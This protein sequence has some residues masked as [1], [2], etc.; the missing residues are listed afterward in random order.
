MS[1]DVFRR[2][3]RTLALVAGMW[4]AVPSLTSA[5][6]IT[7][8]TAT[9]FQ[10]IE[11]FG[12]CLPWW[13]NDPNT[14]P[15]YNPTL[16]SLYVKDL[17]FNILRVEM[18]PSALMGPAGTLDSP[19]ELGDDVA[20]NLPKFNFTRPPIKLYGDFA[21]YV[22]D[23]VIEPGTFKL[24]GAF[25]TP[26]H[27]LK[28]PNGTTI[29][30][31]PAPWINGAD[32]NTCGGRLKQ[33]EATKTQF[34]RYVGAWI[35]GF[36]G[37]YGV[38]WHAVSL[39][40]ELIYET[41]Y[42]SASYSKDETGKTDQWW[43]YADALKAV[44]DYLRTK[45]ISTKLMG[46]HHAGIAG[47]PTNP[48]HF[49]EQMGFIDA[50]RNHAS[51]NLLDSIAIFASNDY[52]DGGLANHAV[53]LRGYWEG[54]ANVPAAWAQWSPAGNISQ[55]GKQNWFQESSG[56]SNNWDK[57]NALGLAQKIHDGLVFGH[58]SAYIYWQ[59]IDDQTGVGP[60]T[61]LGTNQIANPGASKKYSAMKH[62]SRYIR[63]GAQR[64]KAT[65]DANGW[66]A[67]GGATQDDTYNSLNV[68][69]YQKGNALTIVLVNMR[70]VAEPT[71]IALPASLG[72]TSFQAWRTTTGESF[73]AQP[74]LAVSGNAVTVNV[75]AYSVVTL[76]GQGGA[77]TSYT[78]AVTKGGT[79]SGAVTSTPAG[80]ACGATCSASYAS[81][82][83]VTLTA[84]AA[85]GSTFAGWS[86]AC[87][88]TSACV[89][90]MTAARTVTATFN[91]VTPS[92][93]LTVTKAGTG[94]G[95]VAG[96]PISCGATCTATVASGTTVTLAATAASG[97]TFAGWS[98]ACTGTSACVVSMTAARTVTA[99]FNPVTPSYTLTV[100]KAGTG[101]GTVAGGLIHCGTTCAASFPSGT[102]VTLTAT[103]GSGSTFAGWSGACTSSPC[104]VTMTAARSVTATF[105][106]PLND[107]AISVTRSGT[108]AGT[109]TSSTG[110]LNCGTV[111]NV[112][113]AAGTVVT[114]TATP[115]AGSTFGGWS[116]ACAGTAAT[117]TITVTGGHAVGAAFQAQSTGAPCA[118]PITL[119]AGNSGNFNTTG[120]VCYRT[121]AS[122]N[123]WGCYNMAGRTVSVNGG[124]PT[125]ACGQMPLPA[126]WSDGYHYFAFTAGQY[127]WAGLYY[128]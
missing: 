8:D 74:D 77:V 91:P 69:A 126:K 32:S 72:I 119:T 39:Q 80:V 118:N 40:N 38:T 41:E 55:Y 27:W 12:S 109:V 105:T 17:G 48:W 101:T 114:L 64:V 111:C 104:V 62:F 63:P 23:N 106:A 57:D 75:P 25:W 112:M 71:T 58:A 128:W 67:Y 97:S 31:H 100:T 21:Q 13:I 66:S 44:S 113:F 103:P 14:S 7:I 53:M 15:L 45:S 11:G 22:R 107:A 98:G 73:A 124:A 87:T 16:R 123:G 47:M 10:T 19:V 117:C 125:E 96:G 49:Y 6:T 110:G 68:S 46:P 127:P 84:S 1:R 9:K 115:A 36:E 60:Q 2:G 121:A 86:G 33:D 82:T 99:T 5:A 29:A 50:V 102:T 24:V 94:G 4:L 78:L 83:S 92:Y 95:T 90:S 37:Q 59:T 88:G 18:H 116:G 70:S 65:F 56:E 61:L 81:G 79:G 120:A 93:T 35:R 122:V 30:G 85:S 52:V 34:A 42:N 108:G 26:P 20:A 3:A 51:G 89:V 54:I 76:T 28:G 43:Q